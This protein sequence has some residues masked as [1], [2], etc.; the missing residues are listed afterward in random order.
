MAETALAGETVTRPDGRV[1]RSRKVTANAVTDPDDGD[2]LCGVMVLGTHDYDRAKPLADDYAAWQF[3]RGHV[4]TDWITGWWRD[5][6]ENGRR[7]WVNDPEHGRAGVW[8]RE[9]VETGHDVW[10]A[11][12]GVIG[13]KA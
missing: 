2:M 10:G 1:Y 11:D 3:G 8:F 4:A 9:I 13:G 7:C 12:F 5:G 6:F